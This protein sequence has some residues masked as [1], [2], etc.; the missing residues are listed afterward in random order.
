M[1]EYALTLTSGAEQM[2]IMYVSDLSCDAN[3]PFT[4]IY[5]LATDFQRAEMFMPV[6][7]YF[8]TSNDII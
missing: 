3:C 5:I 4:L 8:K 1:T 2:Y 7:R 6:S